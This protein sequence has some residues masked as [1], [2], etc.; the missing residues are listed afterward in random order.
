MFGVK[1]D[2]FVGVGPAHV[3]LASGVGGKEEL[4]QTIKDLGEPQS[5]TTPLHVEIKVLPWVQRMEEIAKK[6]PPGKTPEELE[7]Q[8]EWARRRARAIASCQNGN[9]VIVLDF[10]VVDG[11]VSGELTMETGLLRFAGKLMS[12]FS[13]A[14]FE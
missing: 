2:L 13:K 8:R 1:K 4:K 7:L 10:K 9:D 14:N 6:D 11:E 3:W 5:S 12:A